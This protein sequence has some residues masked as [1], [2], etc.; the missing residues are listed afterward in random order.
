MYKVE[1]TQIR[2]A[3]YLRTSR[4]KRGSFLF[5]SD[6]ANTEEILFETFPSSVFHYSPL[7]SILSRNAVKNRTNRSRKY[8]EVINEKKFQWINMRCNY[9]CLIS[10][11]R[12]NNPLFS[13]DENASYAALWS[14]YDLTERM[15]KGCWN[16][17]KGKINHSFNSPFSN[18]FEK[19]RIISMK[20]D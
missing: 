17:A 14:Y 11:F 9:F 13:V 20:E 7:I 6:Q 2:F 1:G 3:Y 10:F 5:D 16:A 12:R 15:E 19:E 18:L 4:I 8:V